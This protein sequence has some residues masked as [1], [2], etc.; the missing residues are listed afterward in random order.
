[1]SRNTRSSTTSN[2]NDPSETDKTVLQIGDDPVTPLGV[3][4]GVNNVTLKF[5]DGELKY[6]AGIDSEILALTDDYE[7]VTGSFEGRFDSAYRFRVYDTDEK[8]WFHKA[9]FWPYSDDSSS[10]L[11]HYIRH[12]YTHNRSTS[13]TISAPTDRDEISY[14]FSETAVLAYFDPDEERV[15]VFA[16]DERPNRSAGDVASR[17]FQ[18]ELNLY[19]ARDGDLISIT[20][21]AKT[22]GDAFD[23]ETH[24]PTSID[25]GHISRVNKAFLEPPS[26]MWRSVDEPVTGDVWD[27]LTSTA[28]KTAGFVAPGSFDAYHALFV[29]DAVDTPSI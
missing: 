28:E 1:M 26:I 7:E 17:V 13:T 4:I 10:N 16:S 5:T 23:G 8:P 29:T 19:V 3:E 9:D 12:A 25:A 6:T 15:R 24:A 2:N 14:P 22:F 21:S 20:V 27:V 18:P 11:F